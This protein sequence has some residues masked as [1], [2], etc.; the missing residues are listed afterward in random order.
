MWQKG[1]IITRGSPFMYMFAYYGEND[2]LILQVVVALN[3]L[4]NYFPTLK[5]L[6]LHLRSQHAWAD[7]L[8]SLLSVYQGK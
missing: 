8:S 5:G 4:F 7:L 6:F 1:N 2:G 3:H